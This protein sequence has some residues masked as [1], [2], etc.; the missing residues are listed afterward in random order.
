M[1]INEIIAEDHEAAMALD[2]VK[3]LAENGT[4][5]EGVETLKVQKFLA[6]FGID[7]MVSETYQIL[8]ATWVDPSINLRPIF[9]LNV[10]RGTREVVQ[11]NAGHVLLKDH[12]GKIS[13]F[14]EAAGDLVDKSSCTL[15]FATLDDQ[16]QTKTAI[17]LGL[18]NPWEMKEVEL[19]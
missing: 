4:V 3:T 16:L 11:L 12:S 5:I 1:R 8:A 17:H 14:L 9:K 13:R 2:F 10:Y 19:E 18:T 6:K 15:F 7:P